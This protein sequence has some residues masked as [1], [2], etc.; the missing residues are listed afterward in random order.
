MGNRFSLVALSFRDSDQEDVPFWFP[1]SGD[2]GEL[3]DGNPADQLL[4]VTA[5]TEVQLRVPKNYGRIW[6]RVV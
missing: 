3:I 6:S 1:L 2:Y 4:A 5:Y